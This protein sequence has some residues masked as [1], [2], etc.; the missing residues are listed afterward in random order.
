MKYL[1]LISNRYWGHVC[2]WSPGGKAIPNNDGDPVQQ[3]KNSSNTVGKSLYVWQW[4]P[5]G[6]DLCKQN[7]YMQPVGNYCYSG[8]SGKYRDFFIRPCHFFNEL[9]KMPN[10]L[11]DIGILFMSNIPHLSR[12]HSP[13]TRACHLGHNKTFF[14]ISNAQR[15]IANH[16]LLCSKNCVC[17]WYAFGCCSTVMAIWFWS[18]WQPHENSHGELVKCS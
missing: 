15:N 7:Y 2:K 1:K 16:I 5:P 11:S 17:W 13:R 8:P 6:T 4:W 14:K 3:L 18:G 10:D 9:M 12:H